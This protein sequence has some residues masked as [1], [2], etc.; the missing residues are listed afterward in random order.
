MEEADTPLVC[1]LQ[2]GLSAAHLTLICVFCPRR[3]VACAAN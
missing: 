2:L 3:L 1:V